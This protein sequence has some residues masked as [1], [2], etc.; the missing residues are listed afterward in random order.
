D[1]EA[2]AGAMIAAPTRVIARRLIFRECGDLR[3]I[4]LP[5]GKFRRL[6]SL[7]SGGPDRDFDVARETWTV[8]RSRGPDRFVRAGP[9]RSFGRLASRRSPRPGDRSCP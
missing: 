3:A 1:A 9:A 5:S 7:L 2:G 6:A 8:V 4:S